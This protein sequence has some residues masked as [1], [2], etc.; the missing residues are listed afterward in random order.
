MSQAVAN[1]VPTVTLPDNERPDCGICGSG[2]D[3]IVEVSPDRGRFVA[4]CA[5]HIEAPIGQFEVH[6]TEA[7]EPAPPVFDLTP[8]QR[9]AIFAGDHTAIKLEPG[10]HKP[11]VEEGDT[12]VLAR[13]K[14]GKQFLAKTEVERRKRVE[15]DLPLLIDLPSEPSVWIVFH[16]PKLKE[17][18]W[19]LSFDAHDTRESV[20]TL[21]SSPTG[22]RQP[23]L[24]TRQ[25]KRVPKKG[26]YTPP[27]LSDDAAR[28][29]GGGGKSTV[30]E[31]EGVDDAALDRYSEL[32][33]EENL[34]RQMRHRQAEKAARRDTRAAEGRKRRLTLVAKQPPLSVADTAASLKSSAETV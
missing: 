1:P 5:D 20:R 30:D 3:A 2:A 31:R 4:R 32:A 6:L 7:G 10:E 26:E 18:R 8:D 12:V 16:K 33:A 9:K 23:G 27:K 17:G 14:G 22:N 34:R 21:A 28:G 24:K 25:R 13:S 15:E 29:Y 11:D 19:Q